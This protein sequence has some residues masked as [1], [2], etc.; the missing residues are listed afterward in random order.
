MKFRVSEIFFT[1]LGII[2]ISVALYFFNHNVSL[3]RSLQTAS[4]DPFK[5]SYSAPIGVSG[6]V[7]E[8]FV[9]L[10][11]PAPDAVLTKTSVKKQPYSVKFRFEVSEAGYPC[12]FE[13]NFRGKP[14]LSKTFPR[15]TTRVIEIPVLIRVPGMY[16]WRIK[17]KG[18]TTDF[19]TVTIQDAIQ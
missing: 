4:S 12:V 14:L 17:A 1:L 6:G 7:N 9:Q 16:E 2:L 15:F 10:L 18:I 8:P 3:T 5:A 19:R 11:F 13:M